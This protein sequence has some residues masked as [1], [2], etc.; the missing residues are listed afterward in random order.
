MAPE[1]SWK[2]GTLGA[3][4]TLGARLAGRVST[5]VEQQRVQRALCPRPQWRERPWGRLLRVDLPSG[6][7]DQVCLGRTVHL[8]SPEPPQKSRGRAL[9]AQGSPSSGLRLALW[10]A[11]LVFGSPVAI[12]PLLGEPWLPRGQCLAECL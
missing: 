2:R 10:E 1:A 12:Q 5:V 11:A 9:P 3:G 6:G 8:T 4:P 7:E